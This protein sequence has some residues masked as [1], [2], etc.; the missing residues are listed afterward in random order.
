ME[1]PD[2]K[3]GE[4]IQDILHLGI[5]D[6]MYTCVVYSRTIVIYLLD[7]KGSVF[8]V[9]EIRC[10]NPIWTVTGDGADRIYVTY[11]DTNEWIDRFTLCPSVGSRGQSLECQ[12][13]PIQVARYGDGRSR[14]DLPKYE[15]KEML[16]NHL[17]DVVGSNTYMPVK[18][19]TR[20]EWIYFS[21]VRE[22]EYWM[23]RCN[24]EDRLNTFGGDQLPT[25]NTVKVRDLFFYHKCVI[26]QISTKSLNDLKIHTSPSYI[27]FHDPNSQQSL[28]TDH[29]GSM[30]FLLESWQRL[31]SSE[32]DL[33]QAIIFDYWLNRF[34]TISEYLT[35]Y[36]RYMKEIK[37]REGIESISLSFDIP[38]FIKKYPTFHSERFHRLYTFACYHYTDPSR[39]ECF[40][41]G[42]SP[43]EYT[44]SANFEP[45]DE[46]IAGF[47]GGYRIERRNT[48]NIK[49]H[50]DPLIGI[51]EDVSFKATCIRE[52]KQL[53]V[54]YKGMVHVTEAS[55]NMEGER[56]FTPPENM[57]PPLP[58][59]SVSSPLFHSWIFRCVGWALKSG[60]GKHWNNEKWIE[61]LGETWIRDLRKQRQENPK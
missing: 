52:T 1:L 39:P 60:K 16:S 58:M 7:E 32:K 48:L 31:V 33:R 59:D 14:F 51:P 2:L 50:F 23:L 22:H 42:R 24:N 21:R 4:P 34:L 30:F 28:L 25:M 17:R 20:D 46:R 10:S 13:F 40:L 54:H 9:R 44:F 18:G 11:L 57:S 15:Q 37:E 27:I 5:Q 3:G 12:R 49:H 43:H 19:G 26:S 41:P 36:F 47:H 56:V 6:H 29:N 55:R 35:N 45:I 61:L 53:C 8:Q 38:H